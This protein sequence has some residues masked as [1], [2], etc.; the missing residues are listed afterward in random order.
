MD[1]LKKIQNQLHKNIEKYG[2]NSEKTRKISERY[3]KMVNCYYQKERQYNEWNIMKIKYKISMEKLKK[4]TTDFGNFPSVEEW[5]YYAK[6]Q[7]L[8]SSE[9]IKYISGN[10][11]HDLRNRIMSEI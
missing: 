6:K 3:N 11:W 8:L 9:S 1:K 4:L 7:D 5:N 2:L 10:N